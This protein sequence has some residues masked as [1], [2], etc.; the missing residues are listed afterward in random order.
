MDTRERW[1]VLAAAASSLLG[2]SSVAA[3]RFVIGELSPSRLGLLRFGIGTICLLPLLYRARQHRPAA[4]DIVAIALLGILFFAVFPWLFNAALARTTAAHGALALATLP[5]LTLALGALFRRE[6]VTSAK[7]AGIACAMAGVAFALSGQQPGGLL[8]SAGTGDLLMVATAL[9]GALYNVL[10]RPY[11]K[12]YPALVFTAWAMLAGTLALAVLTTVDGSPGAAHSLTR[13]GWIAVLYLGVIGAALTFWLWSYGLEHTTPTRVAITVTLNPVMAMALAV[14]LL[15]EA[16]SPRL[17]IGL[18]GVVAGIA[19]AAW[20][21]AQR[22][23][24]APLAEC[25]TGRL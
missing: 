9:C 7:L 25:P 10:A 17:I 2:G 20:P 15:G 24:S 3:T 16:I 6:A 12:R 13:Q 18:V 1:G 23:V 11:L 21:R 19:I 4:R 22:I 5:L 14:P 8:P